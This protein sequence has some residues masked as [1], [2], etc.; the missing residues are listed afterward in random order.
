[1][2]KMDDVDIKGQNTLATTLAIPEGQPAAYKCNQIDFPSSRVCFMT[3]RTIAFLLILGSFSQA[4][5]AGTARHYFIAAEDVTW[6]FAPTGRDLMH[7]TSL[8]WPWSAQT[9]FAKTHYVEYTD[10]GFSTKKPQPQWLGILGPI[11][12]AEV[13]DMIVVDFLNRSQE[14]HSIHPHGVRYDRQNEGAHYGGQMSDG[15]MVPPSGRFTY[16]WTVDDESGPGPSDGSSV[17]WPYHSHVDAP[18]EINA[19]LIGAIIIT[20]RG[21]ARPDGSPK[22]VDHEFVALFMVFDQSN[23]VE[24]GMFHSIN[25]Y[26]FSNLQGLTANR[27]EH[28]RWYLIGMGSER[29]LHTP[30]W[31]GNTVLVHSQ[32]QD[33]VAL[34]PATTEVADMNATNPGSWMFECHVADH[35]EGGMMATYS[36][37]EKDASSCPV[38]YSDGK[39]QN[40]Q[41]SF[42]IQN[43]GHRI[44]TSVVTDLYAFLDEGYARYFYVTW[45]SDQ[46]IEPGQSAPFTTRFSISSAKGLLGWVLHPSAVTYSNGSQWKASDN[47]EC[48]KIFWLSPDHPSVQELP[49][50]RVD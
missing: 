49:P 8:P 12:R 33:T 25:G 35:M 46:K 1:M 50:V 23:G 17:V 18:L 15:D 36:I 41:A 16:H 28:V 19:G 37:V 2:K 20:A 3:P 14:Y 13:G 32:R 38:D 5:W 10:A 6:D 21:Q 27:G 9:K 22:D 48:F 45:P 31:H 47:R 44:I 39:F 30:H 40:A 7:N 34:L 24:A 26:I 29:D 4:L 11:I 42:S 43:T